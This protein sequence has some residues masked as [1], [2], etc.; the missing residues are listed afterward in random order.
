MDWVQVLFSM[1]IG[2]SIVIVSINLF[3]YCKFLISN[4]D[5]KQVPGALL[6]TV[7]FVVIEYTLIT[8]A[9]ER[10]EGLF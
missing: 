9:L 4:R 7:V 3:G 10:A 5:W 8:I 1:G 2:V 6:F